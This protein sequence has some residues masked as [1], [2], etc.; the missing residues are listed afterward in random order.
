[1]AR[2]FA[3]WLSSF[4]FLLEIAR[5]RCKSLY[6]W[7]DQ[8]VL[9]DDQTVKVK[10]TPTVVFGAY[11][12]ENGKPWMRLNTNPKALNLSAADIE[13]VVSPFMTEILK[14]QQNRRA[15]KN[16]ATK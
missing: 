3:S 5:K 2:I 1:M 12:F 9:V 16:G 11:D 15:Q 13:K 10:G 7:A 6:D 8:W 4:A 14:E